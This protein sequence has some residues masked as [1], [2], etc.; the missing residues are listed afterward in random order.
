M[1]CRRGILP[2]E[3]TGAGFGIWKRTKEKGKSK[4]G[5]VPTSLDGKTR[6]SRHT[7]GKGQQ[8]TAHDHDRKGVEAGMGKGHGV[9]MM[10]PGRWDSMGVCH[11]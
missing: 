2:C 9:A 10:A 3:G 6:V 4:Q 5:K 8:G 11:G 1:I 7:I